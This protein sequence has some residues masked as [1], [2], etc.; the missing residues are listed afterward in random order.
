MTTREKKSAATFWDREFRSVQ[1]CDR[2]SCEKDVGCRVRCRVG[3][4]YLAS[5]G[6][7]C[8]NAPHALIRCGRGVRQH[9][10]KE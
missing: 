1:F 4:S 5:D 9:P 10:E 3:F 7:T 8:G 6:A 2:G